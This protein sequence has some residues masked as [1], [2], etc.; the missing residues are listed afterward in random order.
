MAPDPI[1]LLDM[2]SFKTRNYQD[3][4]SDIGLRLCKLFQIY[5][6][7]KKEYYFYFC[8]NEV[9][10]GKEMYESMEFTSNDWK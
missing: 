7:L 1:F 9:Y 3:I 8:K 10:S 4:K 5:Q 6:S 2:E